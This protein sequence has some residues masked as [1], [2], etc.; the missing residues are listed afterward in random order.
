MSEMNDKQDMVRGNQAQQVLENPVYQ[1]AYTALRADIF[2]KFQKTKFK[3]RDERDELWRKLQVV[4]YIE[5]RLRQ[6]MQDGKIA[7]MTLA[8]KGKKLI[9]L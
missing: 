1:E 8:Q 9:G 4:D 6:T 2:E 3:E 7:E 5:K